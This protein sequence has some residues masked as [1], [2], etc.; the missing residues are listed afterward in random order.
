MLLRYIGKDG[1]NGLVTG[2]IYETKV[3]SRGKALYVSYVLPERG[4]TRAQAYPSP[5]AL[6]A[7]WE[8]TR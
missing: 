7:S 8:V 3:Y 4:G 5:R 1:V 6:A 2:Q